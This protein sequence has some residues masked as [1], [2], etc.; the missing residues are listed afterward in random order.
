MIQFFVLRLNMH[1]QLA[2]SRLQVCLS[3]GKRRRYMAQAQV[4]LTLKFTKHSTVETVP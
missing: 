2:T 3:S 4:K 1:L